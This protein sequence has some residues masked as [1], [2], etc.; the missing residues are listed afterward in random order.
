MRSKRKS[1]MMAGMAQ[2]KKKKNWPP[3][4]RHNDAASCRIGN[5]QAASG[6]WGGR[7]PRSRA[8]L[9]LAAAGYG[10]ENHLA[11]SERKATSGDQQAVRQVD[12]T[13]CAMRDARTAGRW[14]SYSLG[15]R[16]GEADGEPVRATPAV[17]SEELYLAPE[18]G[19]APAPAARADGRRHS[20]QRLRQPAAPR[21]RRGQLPA[22]AAQ[23]RGRPRALPGGTAS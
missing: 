1:D 21:A 8:G 22:D 13:Y 9:P 7:P 16:D 6:P 4:R 15:K 11:S 10:P 20:G 3:R 23:Q 18:P 19:R 5:G 2:R 17:I 14:A 12:S